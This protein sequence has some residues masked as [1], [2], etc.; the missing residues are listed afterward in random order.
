LSVFGAPRYYSPD[1]K[2]NLIVNINDFL[3]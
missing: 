2:V 1:K 3:V